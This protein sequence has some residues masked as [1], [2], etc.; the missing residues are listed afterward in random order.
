MTDTDLPPATNALPQPSILSRLWNGFAHSGIV[1]FFWEII[2]QIFSTLRA[3][4]VLLIQTPAVLLPSVAQTSSK[5]DEYNQELNRRLRA[6]ADEL[7]L[8]AQQKKT[9]QDNWLG[10]IDWTNKRATRER[11]ANELIRW[12]QIVLGVLIPVLVGMD[13]SEA[14]TLASLAGIFVAVLTAIYQFRR[15]EERWQHYRAINERYLAEYWNF[16]VLSEDVYKDAPNHRAAFQRFNARMNDIK[17]EEVSK[18]FSTVVAQQ[19]AQQPG[20]PIQPQGM[21]VQVT[22]FQ[23]RQVEIQPAPASAAI[24]VTPPTVGGDRSDAG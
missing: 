16:I 17:R 4:L 3:I 6:L 24:A 10:Q 19:Q 23:G 1:Q 11:N 21:Q 12:W 7:D 18:F 9:I 14:R 5:D 15:P 22:D 20:Q 8:D 13:S 2:S